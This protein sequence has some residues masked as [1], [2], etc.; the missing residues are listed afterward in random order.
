MRQE[1]IHPIQAAHRAPNVWKLPVARLEIRG[2]AP[3]RLNSIAWRVGLE[4]TP[5]FMTSRHAHR[6][7]QAK[8]NTK[9]ENLSVTI[10]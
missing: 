7:I 9:L 6:V 1:N 8:F 2:W 5:R 4:N 10:V 3:M